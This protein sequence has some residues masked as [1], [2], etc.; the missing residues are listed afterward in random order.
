MC[1]RAEE[2]GSWSLL[3]APCHK[4]GKKGQA[5]VAGD[6]SH[7]IAFV[8]RLRDPRPFLEGE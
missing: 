7:I 3:T 4:E 1:F 8:S 6:T 5:G 2:I